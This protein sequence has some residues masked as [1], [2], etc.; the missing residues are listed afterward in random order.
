MN[1]KTHIFS[2]NPCLYNIKREKTLNQN[3]CNHPKGIL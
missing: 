2:D 3:E 1:K